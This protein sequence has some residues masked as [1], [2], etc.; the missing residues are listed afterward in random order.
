MKDK[1]LHKLLYN[2]IIG[3]GGGGGEVRASPTSSGSSSVCPSLRMYVC[4]STE[5]RHGKSGDQHV[6]P[7]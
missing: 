1:A 2:S 3:G 5:S 4:L 6:G 7:S